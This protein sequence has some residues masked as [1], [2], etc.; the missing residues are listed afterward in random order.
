MFGW[1]IFVP[2]WLLGNRKVPKLTVKQ[3]IT[4]S[5]AALGHLATHVGAVVAF[6]AGAVSFGHIVKASEPVISSVLNFLFMGEVLKWP[7]YAALLPIIGGVGLA[8][9]S[10]MS[11]NWVCFGA[12]MGSNLGSA[13]RAVYSKKVMGGG[14][15][16]ENM[17]SANI[18]AVLTIMATALLIPIAFAIEGPTAML[19]GINAAYA[20]G[21]T[22][23]LK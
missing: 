10:E 9:A 1:L 11:F 12:A 17:D 18:Y 4:L 3:A 21:G 5:P 6:F 16:G 15:I 14:K 20:K 22:T 8:S 13:S 23:F 7:V 19:K 2:L